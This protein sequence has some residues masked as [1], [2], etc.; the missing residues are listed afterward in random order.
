MRPAVADPALSE[1]DIEALAS[2]LQLPLL[3][4]RARADREERCDVFLGVDEDGPFLQ[5]T[6]VDAPG[7]VRCGFLQAAMQHRRRGGQ[8]ELLGRALGIHKRSRSCIVDC[9]VGLDADAFVLADLGADVLLCERHP[10]LAALIELSMAW[11][12]ESQMPA[13]RA[14]IGRMR[15][16]NTDARHC[17]LPTPVDALYLDPM[18]PDAR[19]A[20][21]GKGMRLLQ[22]LLGPVCSEA[23]AALLSWALEQAVARV[24][25]KRPRKAPPVGG[26]T[27]SHVLRGRSVRFDVYQTGRKSA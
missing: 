8:N 16:V 1:P 14:A 3:C 4:A 9:T 2:R 22:A 21:S 5:L 13:M 24:V 7:P 15:L 12:R 27:P 25:V 6:G 20:A 17:T 26:R 23:D 10:L 18:F 11:R 19:R